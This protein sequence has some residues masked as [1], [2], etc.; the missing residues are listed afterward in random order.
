MQPTIQNADAIRV[1][2]ILAAV[3]ITAFWRTALKLLIAITIAATG[4]GVV[5]LWQTM[6]HAAG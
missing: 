5:M 6:Y 2:V 4:Y 3:V 1:L